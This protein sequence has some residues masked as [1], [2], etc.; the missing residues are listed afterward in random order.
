MKN[1]VTEVDGFIFLLH[2]WFILIVHE[3]L[4]FLGNNF[5]F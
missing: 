4:L 2:P 3:F 1:Y 5:N